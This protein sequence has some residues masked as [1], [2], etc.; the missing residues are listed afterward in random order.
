MADQYQLPP[1]E[2]TEPTVPIDNLPP[3]R[4]SGRPPRDRRWLPLLL[5][6][7]GVLLFLGNSGAFAWLAW[8]VL[9]PLAMLAVG[10][11]LITEGRN[12]RRIAIGA[13]VAAPFLVLLVGGANMF[14]RAPAGRPAMDGSATEYIA[15]E[16]IERLRVDIR[17]SA[18][19]LEIR[20]LDPDSRDAFKVDGARAD[21]R[22]EGNT[23]VLVMH[24]SSWQG[25]NTELSIT[26]NVPLEMTVDVTGGNAEPIDLSAIRLE[27]LQLSVRAG[28][29]EVKLP[30]QGVMD[31]AV[32]STAGNI[33]IT[34]PDELEARIEADES[35]FG[36]VD[37]DNDRFE[38]RDDVWYSKNYDAHPDNRATLKLSARA[39]NIEVE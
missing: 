21:F 12:R 38:Q 32:D 4:P 36:N 6:G 11:D 19:N 20:A 10:L 3:S 18:G 9:L 17:Q 25:A 2:P 34:V 14:N 23:G 35:S 16:G 29:T 31:V 24:T 30:Q 8:S 27:S 22:R 26:P 5:I 7:G 37:I 1:T 13:L 28:N 15:L 33:E 39:G